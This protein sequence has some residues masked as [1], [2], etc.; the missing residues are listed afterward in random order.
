M[1]VSDPSEEVRSVY[2][3]VCVC[4]CVFIVSGEKLTNEKWSKVK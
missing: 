3:C 2:V 4:V 1:E